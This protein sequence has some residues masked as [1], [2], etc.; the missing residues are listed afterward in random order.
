MRPRANFRPCK[1]CARALLRV[2]ESRENPGRGRSREW[3][4]IGDDLIAGAL[5]EIGPTA[6]RAP[7][8]GVVAL[9]GGPLWAG[10]PGNEASGS[11]TA[12]AMFGT[13]RGLLAL[14]SGLL[15]R[16]AL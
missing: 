1:S 3:V 15:R 6:A 10:E 9:A 16:F 7:G 5:D 12:G 4:C 13:P 11:V 14:R 2:L 8:V